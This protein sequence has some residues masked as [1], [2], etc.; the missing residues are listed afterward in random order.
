MLLISLIILV[1]MGLAS[2]ALLRSTSTSNVIAGNLAFQQ[3][4]TS[5]ADQATEAAI[6]WLE[7]NKGKAASATASAC[8][9]GSTVLACD[10]AA[11]GFSA[12][13]LDP[14]STQ[15]WEDLWT[16]LAKTITPVSVNNGAA[17][18]AG[19]TMSYVIQRMCSAAGDASITNGCTVVPTSAECGNSKKI[20]PPQTCTSQVYYRITVQVNG[21]RNTVSYTQAMVAL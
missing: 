11:W 15:S 12:T 19:N 10:Q 7:G 1:V 16:A 2:V 6:A 18:G 21:P 17:D 14:T 3:A 8:A 20:G 5:S 9:V 13:R 4:A